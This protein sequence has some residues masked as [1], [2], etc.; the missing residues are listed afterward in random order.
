M[1][2]GTND[3]RSNRHFTLKENPLQR[4]D[5]DDFV[6]YY[7]PKNRHERKES[8]RFKS[9]SYEELLKRDNLT[10]EFL[11]DDEPPF[12]DAAHFLTGWLA[13]AFCFS[14]PCLLRSESASV[15]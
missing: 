6:A 4:S 3:R 1:S 11:R 13:A 9:F 10:L 8:E 7:N 12:A 14:L 2:F 5:L 15:A